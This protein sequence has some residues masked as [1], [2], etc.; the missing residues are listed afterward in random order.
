M[1]GEPLLASKWKEDTLQTRAAFPCVF[2]AT[3]GKLP[4][5]TNTYGS[6]S[7]NQARQQKQT[8]T[9]S[10]NQILGGRGL[11][12]TG[13]ELGAAGQV[14]VCIGLAN[15]PPFVF[16]RYIQRPAPQQIRT[17]KGFPPDPR[18]YT[19]P[20]FS[21]FFFS[22][23]SRPPAERGDNAVGRRRWPSHDEQWMHGGHGGGED[24]REEAR[25]KKT[26]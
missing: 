9:H 8:M 23:C 16:F 15:R 21:C 5:V 12:W 10:P 4:S 17:N 6:Q 1:S 7:R 13:A 24:R 3:W 25:L 18:N 2:P 11:C 14:Y 22:L 19:Y 26:G 20:K